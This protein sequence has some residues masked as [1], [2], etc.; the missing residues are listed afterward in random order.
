MAA[1]KPSQPA[2]PPDYPKQFGDRLVALRKA[3][4]LSQEQLAFDAGLAR[5]YV[6]GVERGL[7]NISLINICILAKA[8]D[9]EPADLLRFD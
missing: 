7:R 8:L 1:K 4:G 2:P 3:K 6:S 5:S 9:M